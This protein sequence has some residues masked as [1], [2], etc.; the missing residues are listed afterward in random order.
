MRPFCGYNMADYFGHWLAMGRDRPA[1]PKIF[2]VNWF[3]TG[4]GGKFLWPGFGEN[5]R[6]LR[7]I[8]DR[9]QGKGAV[10]EAPIGLLPGEGA[11]TP[12]ARCRPMRASSSRSTA[13]PGKGRQPGGVPGASGTHASRSLWGS[14]GRSSPARRRRAGTRLYTA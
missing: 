1:F 11:M 13:A 2:H 3:R 6:V 5:I 8:H 10:R 9:V 12:T 4:E 7:W 14:T